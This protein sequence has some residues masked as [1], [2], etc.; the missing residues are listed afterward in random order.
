MSVLTAQ[1]A[2][3][4][5][6]HMHVLGTWRRKQQQQQEQEGRRCA[7]VQS[8]TALCAT[9]APTIQPTP[10]AARPGSNAT[11]AAAVC[12]HSYAQ[13]VLTAYMLCSR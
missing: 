11:L 10:K 1:P 9:Q 2:C 4:Q 13:C 3:L 5:G 12:R 6:M 8:A 7:D